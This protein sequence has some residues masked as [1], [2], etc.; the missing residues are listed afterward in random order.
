MVF[1]PVLALSA[2]FAS[3]VASP[4]SPRA[5]PTDAVACSTIAASISSA[6]GVFYPG[7]ADYTNDTAKCKPKEVAYCFPLVL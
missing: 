3:A 5:A 7:S 6:S 2:F 4:L 1:A